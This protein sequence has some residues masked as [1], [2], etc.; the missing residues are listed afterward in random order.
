MLK[1]LPNPELVIHLREVIA[2]IDRRDLEAF[3]DAFITQKGGDNVFPLT[4]MLK[5]LGEALV[6]LSDI[7]YTDRNLERSK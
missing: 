2:E 7:S 5:M 1:N 3:N 4:F 6:E